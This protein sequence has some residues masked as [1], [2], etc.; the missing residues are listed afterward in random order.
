[1]PLALGSFTNEI[2]HGSGGKTPP[3]R[4]GVCFRHRGGK[5]VIFRETIALL[6]PD[7]M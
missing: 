2:I 6:G 1:L 5:P 4:R 7:L 3:Q